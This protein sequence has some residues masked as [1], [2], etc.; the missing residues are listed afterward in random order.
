MKHPI[1]L[2]FLSAALIILPSCSSYLTSPSPAASP[3]VGSSAQMAGSRVLIKTGTIHLEV[4]DVRKSTQLTRQ[5]ITKHNGYLE[6]ISSSDDKNA[7]TKLK[8]RLPKDRLTPVMD[9]LAALGKVITKNV[10]VTDVTDEW[11]D[12]QAKMKNIRAMRDRLRTL[13]RQAKNVEDTLKIEKELTRVQSELDSLEGRLKAM[14]KHAAYSKLSL[15]LN[16]KSVPGPIGA[17]SKG[18]WWGIKKLFVIR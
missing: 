9:A 17:A 8:L 10:E 12:L 1:Y 3:S 16:Q 6:N 13:L 2:C 18:V 5:I 14:D 15:T 4:N 11:I 7:Y